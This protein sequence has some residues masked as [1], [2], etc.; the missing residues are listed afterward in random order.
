MKSEKYILLVGGAGYIGS[1]TNKY[2]SRQGY[3]TLVVDNLENGYR[4]FIKYGAFEE[5]NIKDKAFLRSVFEK[6]NIEAVIHFAAYAYVGE[7]VSNPLKYYENNI[8][9]VINLLET[10]Q[11]FGVNYFIFSSTCATYGEPQYTPIDEQHPQVP[12]NPYGKSKLYAENVIRDFADISDIKFVILR[13]FNAAGA[14]SEGELGESHDPETHLI[15]LVI[16]AALGRRE[17][18]TVFGNDYDTEDG[19]CIR[20]YIHVEDLAQAHYLAYRYLEQN[21]SDIFNLGIGHGYSV[22]DVIKCVEKVTG[23]PVKTVWGPKRDGD[24]A[25]LVADATKAKQ[26][27]EW[28]PDYIKLDEI[29]TTAYAWQKGRDE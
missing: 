1:H 22:L 3:T 13:Y 2:F 23:L 17:H 18:I 8:I 29:I 19:T 15:P 21:P 5:G 4:E 12:I 16:D 9:G 26:V 25:V 11:M 6:Y 10:M 24:P 7:S 14:D 27:L 28:K 20:D